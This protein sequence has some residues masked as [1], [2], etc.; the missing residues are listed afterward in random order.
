MAN[1]LLMGINPDWVSFGDARPAWVS[2]LFFN[3]NFLIRQLPLR[4]D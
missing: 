2:G 4:T 3:R 1:L